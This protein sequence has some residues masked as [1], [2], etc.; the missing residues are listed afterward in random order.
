M[1]LEPWNSSGGLCAIVQVSVNDEF[2]Y[3]CLTMAAP[4]RSAGY[5]SGAA[6][7]LRSKENYKVLAL[8]GS[9]TGDSIV[10]LMGVTRVEYGAT[11]VDRGVI[12]FH[13]CPSPPSAGTLSFFKGDVKFDPKH[14]ELFGPRKTK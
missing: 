10:A 6:V 2:Q 9:L 3:S 7:F 13:D 5:D 4:T 12:F 14:L 1:R 8:N 11:A